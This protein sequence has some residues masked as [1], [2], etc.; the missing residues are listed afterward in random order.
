MINETKAANCGGCQPFS[1]KCSGWTK[2]SP[3]R[4][5]VSC[6]RCG[7]TYAR[8]THTAG[9]ALNGCGRI[10]DMK[11]IAVRRHGE[12]IARHNR[13]DREQR[14]FRLP[15]F[16]ATRREAWSWA[17]CPLMLT[18]TGFV[19]HLHFNVPQAKLGNSGFKSMVDGRMDMYFAHCI[20]PFVL[21]FP[22]Q[23]SSS[24]GNAQAGRKPNWPRPFTSR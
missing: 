16:R 14:A 13:N 19:A 15:A 4:R 2:S 24:S 17:T 20:P 1:V 12:I 21:F 5:G 22:E 7:R 3:H 11:L 8:R 23:H 9:V 18:V 6:F 10:D